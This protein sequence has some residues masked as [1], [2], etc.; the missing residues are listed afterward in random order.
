MA[1]KK[2]I[3]KRWWFWVIVV[4]V[5]IIILSALFGDPD[6]ADVS[7]DASPAPVA[8]EQA[9]T[10]QS[11]EPTPTPEPTP[12]PKLGIGST[13]EYEDLSI[14]FN[15][16][17][18]VDVDN[19]FADFPEAVRI[20]MSITNL[21]DEANSLNMFSHSCFDPA[22]LEADSMFAYFDD[23]I[24]NM[25]DMLSGATMDGALHYAYKGDGEYMV[26]FADILGKNPIDVYVDVVKE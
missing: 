24:D 20:E 22:G 3:T 18:V 15:G 2:P 7:T 4:I 10:E 6:D 17:S 8:D 23:N 14:T 5:G 12:L 13:F 26:R 11:Q 1:E 25:G 21:D 19:Q 16:V 9:A